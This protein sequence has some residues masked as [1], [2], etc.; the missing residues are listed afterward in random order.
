MSD[1][2]DRRSAPSTR[3]RVLSRAIG[4]VALA[5]TVGALAPASDGIIQGARDLLLEPRP[6]RRDHQHPQV[7]PGRAQRA[8][9]SRRAEGRLRVALGKGAPVNG[10]SGV[11]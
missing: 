10:S 3:T 7:C 4:A 1:S 8:A 6:G 5:Q 11:T 2:E 9:G